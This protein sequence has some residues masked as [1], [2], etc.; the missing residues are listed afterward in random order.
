M[1]VE[2]VGGYP[3]HLERLYDPKAHLWVELLGGGRVRIGLDALGLETM[4]DV[5]RLELAEVGAVLAKGDTFATV[6]AAKFV[7]TLATPVGGTVCERNSQALEDPRVLAADPYGRGWL[8]ELELRDPAELDQLLRGKDDV[9]AW[10]EEK[11]KEYREKGL[12]AE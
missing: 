11:V 5:V 7:G 3:V 10:F 6:E 9:R 1:A 2:V 4:G 12:L 8:V